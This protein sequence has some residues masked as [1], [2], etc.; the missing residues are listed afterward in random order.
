[1]DTLSLPYLKLRSRLPFMAES[2][3]IDCD[4]GAVLP[5]FPYKEDC[6]DKYQKLLDSLKDPFVQIPEDSLH[7]QWHGIEELHVL[8]EV[9]LQ[10]K[11]KLQG[12]IAAGGEVHSIS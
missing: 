9:P 5:S 11:R 10:T 12:F 6:L 8:E 1:M 4:K 2:K 7:L 3:K